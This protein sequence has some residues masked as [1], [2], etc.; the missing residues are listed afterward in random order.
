MVIPQ[1]I[2]KS[3]IATVQWGIP[4]T[5]EV[6]RLTTEVGRIGVQSDQDQLDIAA[7][8][9]WITKLTYDTDWASITTFTGFTGTVHYR[10]VGI[11]CNIVINIVKSSVAFTGTT[12]LCTLPANFAIKGTPARFLLSAQVSNA[13]TAVADGQIRGSV[14]TV[15]EITL[16]GVMDLNANFIT[17]QTYIAANWL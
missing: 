5:D 3:K 4:I 8:N 12:T 9:D 1:P 2:T 6:N 16:A 7:I 14:G 17:N 15:G 13:S 10:K 11:M